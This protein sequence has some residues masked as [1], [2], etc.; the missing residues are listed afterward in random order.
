VPRPLRTITQI[1]WRDG[2]ATPTNDDTSWLYCYVVQPRRLTIFPPLHTCRESR[3]VWLKHYDRPPRYV[4]LE[5]LDG[6]ARE[7]Y[8]QIWFAVPFI[9]YETDIFA[10][11]TRERPGPAPRNGRHHFHPFMGLDCNRIRHAALRAQCQWPWFCVALWHIFNG[12]VLPSLESFAMISLGPCPDEERQLP[13][14]QPMPLS[15][16]QR[17]FDF[18]LRPLMPLWAMRHPF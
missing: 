18:E 17:P 1:E 14:W 13:R 16:L 6:A 5:M 4:D 8:H 7:T 11:F 10:W 2:L 15:A 3:A 9:S 12:R